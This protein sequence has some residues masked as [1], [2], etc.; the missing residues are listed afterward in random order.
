VQPVSRA[1]AKRTARAMRITFEF[2][3]CSRCC[4]PRRAISRLAFHRNTRER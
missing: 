1:S 4:A 2:L 3:R